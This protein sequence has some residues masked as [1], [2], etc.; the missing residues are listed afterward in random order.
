MKKICTLFIFM[1]FILCSCNYTSVIPE[2]G[3]YTCDNPLMQVN[4]GT[5]EEATGG[6]KGTIT[7]DD[8]VLN[9]FWSTTNWGDVAIQGYSSINPDGSINGDDY[10]FLAD[11]KPIKG[12]N[13]F[14]LT[15]SSS[16]VE[17]Y[18][19]GYELYFSKVE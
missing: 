8:D 18:S 19:Q 12:E 7:I 3:I 1:L 10:F 16:Q 2:E 6:Y 5:Q 13:A 15:I 14:V 17:G 11:L 4:F 9:V